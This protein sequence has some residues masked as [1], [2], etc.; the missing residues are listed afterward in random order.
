M[1]IYRKYVKRYTVQ[2]IHQIYIELKK[3][4]NVMTRPGRASIN[5]TNDFSTFKSIK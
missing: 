1:E 5:L 4:M 2:D 3:Q